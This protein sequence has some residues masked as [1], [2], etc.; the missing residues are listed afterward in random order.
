MRPEK[1]EKLIQDGDVTSFP[2]SLSSASVVLEKTR[3]LE[4]S[5]RQYTRR[6]LK[7]RPSLTES[8]NNK[9]LRTPDTLVTDFKS[10]CRSPDSN[11]ST[12]TNI[13]VCCVPVEHENFLTH[14]VYKEGGLPQQVGYPTTHKFPLIFFVGFIRQLGLPAGR[15]VTLSAY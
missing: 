2:G 9:I 5:I 15:R 7:I 14:P 12:I 11:T 3:A 6:K 10:N 1:D 13:I 8:R 4:A